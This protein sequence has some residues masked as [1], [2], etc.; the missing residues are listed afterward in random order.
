MLLLSA[1]IYCFLCLSFVLF[2]MDLESEINAFMHSFIHK[3]RA[4]ATDGV[5]WSVCVSVGHVRE[6]AKSAEPIDMPLGG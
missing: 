5:A 2:Y 4:I 6:P 1:C 3:M